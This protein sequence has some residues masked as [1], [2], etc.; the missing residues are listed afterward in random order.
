MG[1]GDLYSIS[2]YRGAHSRAVTG[3]ASSPNVP[4]VFASC[5]RDH[6]VSIWDRRL[7]TPIVAFAESHKVGYTTV[8]W[9]VQDE[10][11]VD[12][13]YVGDEAGWI[14]ALDSRSPNQFVT[15]WKV[16]DAPIHRLRFN[17][18]HA[19]VIADSTE[20]KVLHVN[21]QGA[22]IYANNDATDYVR[23][24]HWTSSTELRTIG[25]DSAVRC[26]KL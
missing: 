19:L 12:R 1:S 20:I 9:V 13:I 18:P 14:H 22:V 4:D 16:F 15:S 17:G 11:G 25:W 26:H 8:D 23:D 6:C 21:N 5:S 7:S 24:A 2:T 3:I 10:T